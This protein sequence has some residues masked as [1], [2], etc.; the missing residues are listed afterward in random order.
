MD[1]PA[2][3]GSYIKGR[4]IDMTFPKKEDPDLPMLKM[5]RRF[6]FCVAVEFTLST[7]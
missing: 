1:R 3:N 2:H 5:W 4:P 7:S 6:I